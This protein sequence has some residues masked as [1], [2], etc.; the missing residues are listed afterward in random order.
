LTVRGKGPYLSDSS[1]SY[2][3]FALKGSF[4]L[5]CIS[6]SLISAILL[7]LAAAG[8]AGEPYI[9][10]DPNTIWQYS[11]LPPD[12]REVMLI[13]ET[14]ESANQRALQHQSF[15]KE[16]LRNIVSDVALRHGLEP[17]LLCAVAWTESR[18]NPYVVSNMGAQGL[19]QL[20]PPTSRKFGVQN[21]MN[22]VDSAE[23]GARYMRWLLDIYDGDLVLSLAA[24]N[25]GTGA[26]KKGGKV[27]PFSQ[28]QN[29]VISVLTMRDHFKNRR[30]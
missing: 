5:R 12:G 4:F 7:L 6:L 9:I 11:N 24:Y 16:E 15:D 21:P 19:M 10:N 17:E 8:N 25:A 30:P 22:P 13:N 3:E 20:M 2:G 1:P 26:V 29:F 28:T 18:F 27:P 14:R 23:G